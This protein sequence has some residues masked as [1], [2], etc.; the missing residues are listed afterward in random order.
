[1]NDQAET[2][3]PSPPSA[4]YRASLEKKG[5]SRPRKDPNDP[6]TVLIMIE[7]L[8]NK[9][10]ALDTAAWSKEEAV[11]VA[12]A[13]S[14]FAGSSTPASRRLREAWKGAFVSEK[15]KRKIYQH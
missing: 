7:K 1:M 13:V 8:T 9:F 2:P 6:A 10:E 15:Q 14:P 3:H 4:T 12:G 11:G 5:V